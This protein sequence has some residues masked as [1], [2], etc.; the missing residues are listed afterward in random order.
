MAEF[1][2]SM[3]KRMD[4]VEAAITQVAQILVDQSERIDGVR[5]ELHTTRDALTT[6]L[7][8][9]TDRL[10]VVTDRLDVVTDRLDAVTD[11]LDRLIDV[12][13]KERT[14]GVERIPELERRIARL[15]QHAGF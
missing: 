12:S 15:E 4:R 10:D 2:A 7:D 6:R 9:V 14:F 3:K 5:N 11:R 1:E 13:I 8:A